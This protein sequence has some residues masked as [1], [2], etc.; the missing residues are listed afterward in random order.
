MKEE[1]YP[2]GE[3]TDAELNALAD[4]GEFYLDEDGFEYQLSDAQLDRLA[5]H[6]QRLLD[7]EN[8][9]RKDE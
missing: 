7:L 2:G 8:F 5:D 9:K 1:E 6:G 3:F 4:A